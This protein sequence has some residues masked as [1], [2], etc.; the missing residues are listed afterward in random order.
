MAAG[1][2]LRREA[3]VGG[4]VLAVASVAYA[5]AIEEPRLHARFGDAYASYASRTPLIAPVPGKLRAMLFASWIAAR[6]FV[7]RLANQ[8][9]LMR[10]KHWALV[11][12]V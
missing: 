4:L 8:T 9:V 2:E 6:P 10:G 1:L 5:H 7:E 3:I 12:Y 11:T